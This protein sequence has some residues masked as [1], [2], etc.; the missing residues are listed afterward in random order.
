MYENSTLSRYRLNGKPY[1]YKILSPSHLEVT[2]SFFFFF[3]LPEHNMAP[4]T[5]SSALL[6]EAKS[7]CQHQRW[8]P[9]AH[10][11]VCA[12]SDRSARPSSGSLSWHRSSR[13]S[14][15]APPPANHRAH[16]PA[17]L[18]LASRGSA[19]SPRCLLTAVAATVL[20]VPGSAQGG[21]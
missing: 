2:R 19:G 4:S 16:R 3:F 12:G 13:R 21:G 8:Q 18:P 5:A 10:P 14:R 7:A 15:W 17:P 11:L 1:R 20:P 6:Q 9:G